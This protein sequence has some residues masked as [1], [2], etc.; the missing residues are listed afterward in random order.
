MAFEKTWTLVDDCLGRWSA[1]DLE[2]VLPAALAPS[3]TP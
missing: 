3:P 2:V 1:A